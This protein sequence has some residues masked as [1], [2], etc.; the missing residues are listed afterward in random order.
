M[1]RKA[2]SVLR[3]AHEAPEHARD[4]VEQ[5]FEQGWLVRFARNGHLR[6]MPPGSRPICTSFSP[7]DFRT[8]RN[9]RSRLRRAGLKV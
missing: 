5:A 3:S 9:E 7:S 8:I 2:E 6:F 4:W 1:G